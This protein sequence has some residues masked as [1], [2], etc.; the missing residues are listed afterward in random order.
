MSADFSHCSPSSSVGNPQ[1]HIIHRRV[2]DLGCYRY[3]YTRGVDG[4]AAKPAVGLANLEPTLVRKRV[5]GV[6]LWRFIFNRA[7]P[8]NT[9]LAGLND[10]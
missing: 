9:T 3:L 8:P 7:I 1:R 6:L 4:S 2:F 5:I 10:L